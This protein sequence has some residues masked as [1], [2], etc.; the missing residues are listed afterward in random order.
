MAVVWVPRLFVERVAEEGDVLTPQGTH[1]LHGGATRH[2]TGRADAAS[3]GS[4]AQ[5]GYSCEV[6]SC[7]RAP[8][9]RAQGPGAP[10]LLR[11]LMVPWVSPAA[12]PSPIRIIWKFYIQIIGCS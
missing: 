3:W 10:A 8:A 11:G 9:A 12:V 2:P 7:S 5:C 6:P 1:R 4:Q